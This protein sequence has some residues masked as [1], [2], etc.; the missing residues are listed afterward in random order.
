MAQ[1]ALLART[2]LRAGSLV[3][4]IRDHGTL[5]FTLLGIMWAVELFDLLPFINPDRFG[6]QPRSISGLTGIV[7]SP[8]LHD[9]FGHLI[10]NSVPFIVLG[11]LVLF[12]GRRL[13][14][15]VTLFVMIVGGF[16]V[17][18]FAGSFTNHIGASGLIFGYLGF[19]LTRG[20][21]ERSII[22]MLTALII[23]VIYG[24]L[25]FGVLPIRVGVS[26]QSHLFGFLAGVAAAR[27]LF[28]P[29]PGGRG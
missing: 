20:Y 9:G 1:D 16:G 4:T 21:F 28:G 6:I 25:L 11:G 5:L 12:G 24:S 27:L 15:K 3:A 23:L 2:P 8:F 22:W 10:A 7:C 26:W 29:A 19:L 14:W 17:W 18:L 13:F